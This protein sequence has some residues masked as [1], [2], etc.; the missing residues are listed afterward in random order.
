MQKQAIKINILCA[1]SILVCASL[2]V[3]QTVVAPKGGVVQGQ[4]LDSSR[5]PLGGAIVYGIPNSDMDAR[6]HTTTDATGRFYL[7]NLP[8][9]DIYLH[10]FKEDD[11]YPDNIF[12]FYRTSDREWVKV[13]VD[14]GKTISDV[15]IELGQRVAYL[16]IDI[17][18]EAGNALEQGAQL[19][20]TR[21]DMPGDYK[22][23]VSAEESVP[24]PA[25][26][27]RVTVEVDGYEPWHYGGTEWQQAAGLLL[28]GPGK[29]LPLSV[30]MHKLSAS[31]KP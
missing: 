1:S 16:K 3:A 12:S 15:S 11:G 6:F 30:R 25:V 24:I 18:D 28:V 10:A 29:T 19:I 4:V 5:K 31:A 23:G 13:D 9:G 14:P 7:D 8:K 20:C 2:L 17:S 27:F 26:P 22:R 21:P